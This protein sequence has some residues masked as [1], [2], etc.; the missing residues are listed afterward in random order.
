MKGT[1][2]GH[3]RGHGL[4]RTPKENGTRMA[5]FAFVLWL[6]TESTAPVGIFDI[7]QE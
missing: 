4:R 6:Y 3:C 2:R 5:N 7:T 1:T